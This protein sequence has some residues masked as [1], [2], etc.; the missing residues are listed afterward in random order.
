MT[1]SII[2]KLAKLLLLLLNTGGKIR[3]SVESSISN[4]DPVN[5]T[6]HSVPPEWDSESLI[7]GCG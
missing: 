7:S 6:Q 5:Y 3:R 1:C 2:I 4:N